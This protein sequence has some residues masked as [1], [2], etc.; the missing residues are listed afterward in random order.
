M[1]SVHSVESS[2]VWATSAPVARIQ[3]MMVVQLKIIVC[4]FVDASEY[5]VGGVS[6]ALSTKTRIAVTSKVH[7]A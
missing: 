6:D 7:C 4:C 2:G 3:L 1:M 5:T